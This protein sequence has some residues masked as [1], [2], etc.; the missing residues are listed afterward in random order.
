[1]ND[2]VYALMV[3]NGDIFAGGSFETA[4]GNVSCYWA[5]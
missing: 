2:W 1:M 5:R 4:G 3:Y